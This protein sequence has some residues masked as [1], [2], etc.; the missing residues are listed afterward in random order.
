MSID[1]ARSYSSAIYL[2]RCREAGYD[3]APSDESFVAP[4]AAKT[5]RRAQPL[6]QQERTLGPGIR[7]VH[8]TAAAKAGFDRTSRR[9]VQR[10]AVAIAS[11]N[12]F[13]RGGEPGVPDDTNRGASFGAA[14]SSGSSRLGAAQ[15]ASG[16]LFG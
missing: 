1:A 11:H 5:T 10:W 8:F 9:G 13:L 4:L 12:L 2:L 16:S 3:I 7:A 14:A 6:A 15:G